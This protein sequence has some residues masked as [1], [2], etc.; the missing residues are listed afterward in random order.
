MAQMLA[1]LPS[2]GRVLEIGTGTGYN[3]AILAHRYG[4]Q[5]VVTVEYDPQ[6]ADSARTVLEK[7]GYPVTVVRGDG[8]APP[9]IDG[10]FDAIIATCAFRRLPAAW[11]EACPSGR[12]IFPYATRW[13]DVA[14]LVL[15][16][17]D[18]AQ[19]SG[20]FY[21]GFVFMDSRTQEPAD[22]RP[23]T[24]EGG[25][26]RPSQLAPAEVTWQAPNAAF[27][28]GLLVPGVDYR[29]DAEGGNTRITVWDGRGSWAVVDQEP[30]PDGWAVREYG[31]RKLWADI[32]TAYR[33]WTAWRRP[34][35]DRFTVQ[36][37]GGR[38]RV[39]LD[40]PSRLVAAVGLAT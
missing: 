24:T 13:S 21:P 40:E 33:Q 35:P 10:G 39:Y 19:A 38:M 3:S 37:T 30:G 17:G 25:V 1:V 2:S 6:L 4:S 16:T 9:Q 15:D 34:S 22:D 14:A 23:R 11:I 18:G 29:T 26:P 8:A 32:E 20:R 36:A 28:I 27:A 12:I 5:N 7:S 31:P